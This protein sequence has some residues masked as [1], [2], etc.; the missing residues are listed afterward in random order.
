MAPATAGRSDV[1]E[2][3][4]QPVRHEH[5]WVLLCVE[6]DDGV[7]VREYRCTDC[8]ETTFA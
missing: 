7:S 3:R 5:T 2:G 8:A 4:P 1:V 6:F